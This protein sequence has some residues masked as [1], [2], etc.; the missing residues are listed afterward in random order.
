MLFGLTLPPPCSWRHCRQPLMLDATCMYHHKNVFIT[1][2]T[3]GSNFLSIPP[4]SPEASIRAG[5]CMLMLE[6]HT[7]CWRRPNPCPLR[8][9]RFS[10]CP[11]SF[12]Q[13][14]RLSRASIHFSVKHPNLGPSHPPVQQ[15]ACALGGFWCHARG[16]PASEPLHAAVQL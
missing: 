9:P 6:S 8:N 7:P 16:T 3:G 11:G 14:A 15:T 4:P 5:A 13:S 10:S 2:P 1:L 12:P